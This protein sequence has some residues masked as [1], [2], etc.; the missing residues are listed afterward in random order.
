MEHGFIYQKMLPAVW[1]SPIHFTNLLLQIPVR[2]PQVSGR[3][4][5]PARDPGNP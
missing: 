2:D 1:Q 4:Y 3:K 5:L